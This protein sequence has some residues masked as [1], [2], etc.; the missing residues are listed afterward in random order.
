V[1]LALASGQSHGGWYGARVHRCGLG[2]VALG[3]IAP[4]I[5]IVLANA[6]V[7]VSAGL[8]AGCGSSTFARQSGSGCVRSAVSAACHVLFIGNSFTIVN[9]FP[10]MFAKLANAGNH[11]VETG[12]VAKGGGTLADYAASTEITTALSSAKWDVVVLQEQSEIPS[13]GRLRQI[14]MYPAAR[15]LVRLVHHAG[16]QP[17]FFITWAHRE[18]WPQNGLI[19]Y[20]SMQSA[21]DQGYLVIA[22][23]LHVAVAPVGEAWSAALSQEARSGLWQRD[24]EHPTINGTYLAACVFYAA[25]F[26]ESP[27]GLQY[28]AGLPSRDATK[29]QTIASKVILGD[30]VRWGL[31]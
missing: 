19:G 22:R 26:R 1:G 25:V 20:A 7:A 27:T 6:I 18:G 28:H 24:G 15:Q 8:V 21:I 4:T 17:M 29:L 14:Q 13:I 5:R 11:A 23:E 9:N 10:A 12:I 3:R 16:A 31:R 2:A 30:P